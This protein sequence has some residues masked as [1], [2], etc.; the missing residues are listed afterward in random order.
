MKD[1]IT[2]VL[3]NRIE[4]LY[5]H[6]KSRFLDQQSSLFTPRLII[7]PD[8]FCKSYLQI[9]L[10]SEG[11]CLGLEILL[12][13]QAIERMT[14][15]HYSTFADCLSV[16]SQVALEEIDSSRCHFLAHQLLRQGWHADCMQ[17]MDEKSE[18]ILGSI[19]DQ[20][21]VEFPI[22]D[23]V[24]PHWHTA[25][26]G[27]SFLS[28]R[29]HQ[30]F[31]RAGACYFILSPCMMY[32]GDVFSD[33]EMKRSVQGKLHVV[34]QMAFQESSFDR[35]YL[36][37]NCGKAGRK[38]SELLEES[39][40]SSVDAYVGWQWLLS[41][42]LFEPYVREYAFSETVSTAPLNILSALQASLLLQQAKSDQSISCT[43]SDKSFQVHTA[44]TLLREVQLL[45]SHITTFFASLQKP[46][47]NGQCL[48][49]APDIEQYRPYIDRVF[50][51]SD[52]SY[53]IFSDTK[54]Q[55]PALFTAFM[56]LLE[57]PSKRW[58]ADAVLEL[59]AC[60][61]LQN[62]WNLSSED[63]ASA[64]AYMGL[65]KF[66]WGYDGKQR[67][68]LLAAEGI[69]CLDAVQES[70]T[71]AAFSRAISEN[72]IFAD[73][74]VEIDSGQAEGI[75]KVIAVVSSI[76]QALEALF[77][78]PTRAFKEW[79]EALEA[80]YTAYFC[81][82][83]DEIEMLFV[84]AKQQPSLGPISFD[85]VKE[86][87]I[88]CMQELGGRFS[89][90]WSSCI[91]FT[92]LGMCHSCPA[93]MVCLIGMNSS[94]FPRSEETHVP[95]YGLPVAVEDRY[96]FIEAVL[97]ARKAF[98]I[99]YQS[100]SYEEKVILEPS[101]CVFDCLQALFD[102]C[103]VD[104]RKPEEVCVQHHSLDVP[105]HEKRFSHMPFIS[106]CG[107]ERKPPIATELS[108]RNLDKV[109][110]SPL[111]LYFQ[112]NFSLHLEPSLPVRSHDMFSV[113]ETSTLYQLRRKAFGLPMK[114]KEA[115][116]ERETASLP[117][118][119]KQAS[120]DLLKSSVEQLE[121]CA[122]SIG[123]SCEKPMKIEFL[124]QCSKPEEVTERHWRVPAIQGISGTVENVYE[125]GYLV[126]AKQSEEQLL[127]QWPKLLLLC[128]A[129]DL[130]AL[131]VRPQCLFVEDAKVKPL[132]FR[133]VEK[134]LER[135][136]AYARDCSSKPCCLYPEWV[137]AL[138]KHE[139]APKDIAIDIDNYLQ[140]FLSR[141]P[142]DYILQQWTLWKAQAMELFE[143]A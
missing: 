119:F 46:L 49:M 134:S 1:K 136:V 64:A 130:F 45:Q 2:C 62:K 61:Q 53:Q 108:L 85:L 39:V 43:S 78:V 23:E 16:V 26:F 14:G 114:E 67:Q 58:S 120:V 4:T 81:G 106:L 102:I 32:W 29:L 139:T 113:I 87:L 3:S 141:M 129:I 25:L 140:F 15:K 94:S 116:F 96:F 31:V 103:R 125:A 75:G 100:F 124:L 20:K 10:A 115:L 11:V 97:A 59:L 95:K 74:G 33:R 137:V 72:W 89:A 19:L 69:N 126:F 66:Q 117:V 122:K 104:G 70:G 110:R 47:T 86:I 37:A 7:V 42:P 107:E 24:G 35:N 18:K 92:S 127:K 93:D 6:L 109:A 55:Y 112:H 128:A 8:L 21:L 99:S 41:E 68:E 77:S 76:K 121:S 63:L 82:V 48:V 27:F 38:F 9:Q 142:E 143:D 138:R 80:L 73:E 98:Y 12:P 51:T 84:K 17:K 105:L 5:D 101:I 44:P 54:G 56:N 123:V 133:N 132:Q 36:L 60:R 111:Q 91:I 71:F 90:P 57:L 79:V 22:L 30:F 28:E 83:S 118:A 65:F 131:P 135:Y 34:S 52:C 40:S 88:A 13:E 50:A